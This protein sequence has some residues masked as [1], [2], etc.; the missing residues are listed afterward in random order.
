MNPAIKNFLL[1]CAKNAL[2]AIL[3]NAALMTMM[4]GVF[5][6]YSTAGLWNLGKAALGVIVAREVMVWGPIVLSWT[7]TSAT[8]DSMKQPP[9][10]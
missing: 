7:N 6:T 2:N 8:P 4:H 10:A 1:I 3:T 5:N 9:A